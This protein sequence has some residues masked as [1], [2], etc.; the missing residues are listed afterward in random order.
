MIDNS[1][2]ILIL[3]ISIT[4]PILCGF[5]F[6]NLSQKK[7]ESKDFLLD[8]FIGIS[9]IIIFLQNLVYLNVP[10]KY[11]AFVLLFLIIVSTTYILI[12]KHIKFNKEWLVIVFLV[13]STL[14]VNGQGYFRETAKHYIGYGWID[15]YN[16]VTIAEFLKEYKFKTEF[17]GVD[18]PYLVS[19]IAKKNDR[20][21]QSVFQ[22]FISSITLLPA[23]YT[24]G[25][26]S[27][28]SPVLTF[29]AFLY[30]FFILKLKKI[31]SYLFSF[32]VSVLPA[33]STVHLENFLSQA[34]GT[35]ML[36]ITL[37]YILSLRKIVI[38]ELI[39]LG[40][41]I[42]GTNS[43]YTEYTPFILLVILLTILTRLIFEKNVIKVV[44]G[45]LLS[46]LLALIINPFFSGGTLKI[47]QRTNLVGILSH[48]YPFS[49]SAYGYNRLF[50]GDLFIQNITNKY[51]LFVIILLILLLSIIGSLFFL[52]KKRNVYF[53]LLMAFPLVSLILN[54]FFKNYP[55]QTYKLLLSFFPLLFI[56]IAYLFN[57]L[58]SYKNIILTIIVS[59]LLIFLVI[60][61]VMATLELSNMAYLGG[62]R[63]LKYIL[64]SEDQKNIYEKLI[65]SKGQNIFL[66]TTH[67][68]EL[69]W[70][71][72]YGRFNNLRFQNT[73]I[74]DFDTKLIPKF[75][76]TNIVNLPKNTIIVDGIMSFPKVTNN[77][78]IYATIDGSIEGLKE[79]MWSWL[80][81][82]MEMNIYSRDNIDIFLT[83]DAYSGPANKDDKR[84]LKIS[85]LSTKE[86]HDITFYKSID[87]VKMPFQL[88]KGFNDFELET[89]Y[90]KKIEFIPENDKR[91][92]M[93]M[94]KQLSIE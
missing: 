91:I 11:S 84:I 50:F 60:I 44:V 71:V 42:A 92:F 89:I 57:R 53:L 25:A 49:H 82:K 46:I 80:G 90:P 70:M 1:L 37:V 93:I 76:Y 68:Y 81:E 54:I 85:N 13:G 22:A 2:S 12:K 32:L 31:I 21:G 58:L 74:G 64:N 77:K 14:F 78:N 52:F 26:V 38:K 28:L 16:Y 29:F 15:G 39:I 72:Y 41:L 67:P 4:I 59:L 8:P 36:I 63:S 94:I 35:P 3:V 19:A 69:A 40:L 88:K 43:I 20:I 24:Y 34:L 83:F 79:D 45:F 48:V 5:L 17:K 61:P 55:Y 87:S 65:K 10:V 62:G 7:L 56:G 18:K 27:L 75:V 86:F 51:Y 30:L 23:N 66:N 73:V 33:V 9:I 47:F 6:F